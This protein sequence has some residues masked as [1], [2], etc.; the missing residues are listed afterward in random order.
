MAG[1]PIYEVKVR[2]DAPVTP[3]Q[4]GMSDEQI[5][6][7]VD[8]KA[9]EQAEEIAT[10]KVERLKEELASSITGK[11]HSRYGDGGPESWDKLHDDVA[12]DAT[13]RAVKAAEDRIDK[14][15]ADKE[16]ASDDERKQSQAQI[17]ASQKAEYA[18]MSEEWTEAVAD[19]I[20]PDIASGV[21]S[22]L[23]SGV[24]YEDLTDDEKRDPGLRA[25][26]DTRML[27]AKLRSEGKSKSFYRTASQ[28]YGKRP[29]G[30]SAPVMGGAVSS[31]GGGDD[32]DYDYAEIESNRKTK[33]G[34]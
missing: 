20:L 11:Q 25:Y 29:A 5:S 34:F 28:F 4:S 13:E 27:H 22:K 17:E 21:K 24:T 26:N 16:K 31:P 12:N 3:A 2:D 23:K 14:R 10:S 32:G 19:G 7:L 9:R 8:S 18:R 15:F 33:F 1:E 6:S 30:A